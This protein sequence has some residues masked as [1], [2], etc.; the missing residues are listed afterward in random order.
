[1]QFPLPLCFINRHRP[2]RARAKWDGL[3]YVGTCRHCGARIRRRDAGHWQ[4]DWIE[5]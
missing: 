2:D 4:K 3:H 5:G 1:M